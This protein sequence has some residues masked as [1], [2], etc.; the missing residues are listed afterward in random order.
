[1]RGL[2]LNILN[3]YA[4]DASTECGVLPGS[5]GG[6]W[7][8]SYMAGTGAGYIG[9]H[10]YSSLVKKAA[11]INDAVALLRASLSKD[12]YKLITLGVAKTVEVEVVYTGKNRV[13][14][15]ITF[16]GPA[17]EDGRVNLFGERIDNGW[18]WA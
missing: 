7:S 13:K 16:T 9:T 11:S 8:E 14:A 18:V 6:H 1:M 3:T 2:L 12:V 5:Q 10:I 4:R 17:S 15:D